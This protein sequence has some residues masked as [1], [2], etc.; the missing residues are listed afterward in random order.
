MADL[1][2]DANDRADFFLGLALREQQRV[3]NV[4]PS[5][6][7]SCLNCGTELHDDKRRWCNAM[8]RDEHQSY[9]AREALRDN[10]A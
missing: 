2:D 5:G 6:T 7:G 9:L 8:C 4:E 10:E 3:A 1:G